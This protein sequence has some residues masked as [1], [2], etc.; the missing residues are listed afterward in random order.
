MVRKLGIASIVAKIYE[1]AKA[2]TDTRS[3]RERGRVCT[4]FDKDQ[5]VDMMWY[6]ECPG[7]NAAPYPASEANTLRTALL[8]KVSKLYSAQDL[9][10]WGITRLS[11]YYN[12][13]FSNSQT[14]R[15]SDYVP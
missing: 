6:T 14:P 12:L 9:A 4:S 5:L 2:G 10:T 1:T 13:L 7:V 11:Y 3:S 15:K 8:P